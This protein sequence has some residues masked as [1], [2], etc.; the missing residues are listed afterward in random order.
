VKAG[1]GVS[2]LSH[3]K[4]KKRI[5]DG[6]PDLR[7]CSAGL[8]AGSSAD[9][10]VR[11][12]DPCPVLQARLGWICKDVSDG[13]VEFIS[14]A[15]KAVVVLSLPESAFSAECVVSGFCGEVLP[16]FDDLRKLLAG[17]QFRHNVN[18]V[19]HDAPSEKL[20][21]LS[22]PEAQGRSHGASDAMVEECA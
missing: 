17:K 15:N 20:V 3:P 18:V 16:G 12:P 14:V 22:L 10:P 19:R 2:F 6:A 13:A 11:A 4:R 21:V 7:I 1:R 5:W 9:F 8:L